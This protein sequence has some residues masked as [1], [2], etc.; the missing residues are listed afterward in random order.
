MEI[1]AVEILRDATLKEDMALNSA[2][3][4]LHRTPSGAGGEAEVV[5]KASA[6]KSLR[7]R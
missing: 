1:S 2:I 7:T 6:H 5:A 3:T 4:T